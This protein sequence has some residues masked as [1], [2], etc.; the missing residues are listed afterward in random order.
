[1]FSIFSIFIFLMLLFINGSSEKF[2]VNCKHYTKGILCNEIF[3]KC[4]LFSINSDKANKSL[5]EE[6]DYLVVGKKSTEY[7]FCTT[8]R[9]D[10]NMCG[11]K[12]KLYCKKNKSSLLP[13]KFFPTV[14]NLFIDKD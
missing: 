8:A 6:V 4:K 13:I 11:P 10:E 14:I 7:R 9:A 3:G 12:G 1:M 5:A 2:C